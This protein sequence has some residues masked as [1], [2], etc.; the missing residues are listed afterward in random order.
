MKR[1][2]GSTHIYMLVEGRDELAFYGKILNK[3]VARA[4]NCD[5][6]P[7]V[8]EGLRLLREVGTSGVFASVD[9]DYDP[10]FDDEDIIH[11]DRNDLDMMAAFSDSFGHTLAAYGIAEHDDVN[12]DVIRVDVLR[13]SAHIGLL[14]KIS[15]EENMRLRFSE[16]EI[17]KV[18]RYKGG[19]LS[20]DMIQLVDLVIAATQTPVGYT[21]YDLCDMVGAREAELKIADIEKL[22]S[23]CR[24]HDFAG[25]LSV[26]IAGEVRSMMKKQCTPGVVEGYLRSCY[27]VVEFS[28]SQM[29]QKILEWEKRNQV[30]ILNH[31][32]YRIVGVA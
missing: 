19:T 12:V 26:R 28:R 11:T 29:C 8:I 30:S 4:E 18:V 17:P 16:V 21:R 6:K 22:G 23:Y 10:P 7:N 1:E 31:E 20:I 32:I 9:L 2:Q 13:I 5:G 25:V 15:K 14:R 27:G 24:G 3:S